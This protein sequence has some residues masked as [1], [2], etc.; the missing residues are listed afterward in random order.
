MNTQTDQDHVRIQ[1]LLR[2]VADLQE[3]LELNERSYKNLEQTRQNDIL[4][5]NNRVLHLE[6]QLDLERNAAWNQKQELDCKIEDLGMD[7]DDMQTALHNQQQD[8]R[9]LETKSNKMKTRLANINKNML[10]VKR[11]LRNKS[12]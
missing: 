7:L 9:Q 10:S 12:K 6:T 8:Y 4:K 5:L 11:T 2:V 3:Q 1:R